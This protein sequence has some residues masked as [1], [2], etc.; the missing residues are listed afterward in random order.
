MQAIEVCDDD[1]AADEYEDVAEYFV[2]KCTEMYR[3][4]HIYTQMYR[5]VQKCTQM[6]RKLHKCKDMHRNIHKRRLNELHKTF[7]LGIFIRDK[8]GSTNI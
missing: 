5:N 6:R 8:V 7:H 4:V 1:D 3:N 2:H